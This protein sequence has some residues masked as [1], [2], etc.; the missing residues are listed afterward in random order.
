MTGVGVVPATEFL[1]NSKLSMTRHG[2][3]EVDRHMRV[4]N[5]EK[6]PFNNVYAGGDIA[7]FPLK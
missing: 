7:F 4:L 3:V 2:F 6:E 1:K 5:E